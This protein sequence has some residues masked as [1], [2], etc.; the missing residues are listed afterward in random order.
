MQLA[1]QI[2]VS[3][4]FLLFLA[5]FGSLAGGVL[6]LSLG[7]IELLQAVN[8]LSS[9]TGSVEVKRVFALVLNATDTFLF[10]A[11][12]FIFA[13]AITFSFIIDVPPH[14]RSGLPRSMQAQGVSQLKHTLAEV[15]LIVLVVDFASDVA[16]AEAHLDW[17]LL[18]VPIA[19]LLIAVALRLLAAD[20]RGRDS[21]DEH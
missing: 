12:L 7:V 17:S 4:R 13:Y 8:V 3:L 5:S 11:V 2:F 21:E 16:T 6:M 18:V 10:G 15:V 14:M 1:L 9:N 20:H 19:I